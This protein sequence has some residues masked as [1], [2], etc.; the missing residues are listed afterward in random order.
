MS[1]DRPTTASWTDAVWVLLALP[2]VAVALAAWLGIG[3]LR[4]GPAGVVGV[5]AVA[6]VFLP[7]LGITMAWPGARR[8]AMFGLTLAAWSM[9]LLTTFPIYFPGERAAALDRGFTGMAAL[10]GQPLPP[11]GELLDNVL[12]AI[13]GVPPVDS[14]SVV[15]VEDALAVAD[16]VVVAPPPRSP[17]PSTDEVILP[18]EGSGSSLVV[19]VG[20]EH[21]GVDLDVSMIFDTG[22]SFTSVDSQTLR[23]LGVRIPRDAPEVNVRTANGER[24][25]KLV[26][27]DTVWLGGFGVDGVTVAVCDA[28][29]HDNEVGLLGLNVSGRFLVTVDQQ[30]REL[31]L[32][33]RDNP[34]R[35]ADVRYWVHPAAKATAWPDGRVEVDVTLENNSPRTVR[36]AV[37]RI[38]CD[39][40]YDVR[41]PD[42]PPGE[43]GEKQVKLR[44]GAECEGYTVELVSAG[45]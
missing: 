25:M 1:I 4:E 45:W 26:L 37:V 11:L 8:L 28:C 21:D 6:R 20:F 41:L 36:G 9:V 7:A 22:A 23:D 5:L 3:W 39:D 34:D 32:R 10:V 12:P 38:G 2:F 42:V 30:T 29:R 18:Y 24:V 15:A 27:V 43:V 44:T 17:P 40:G 33:P 31:R 35:L 13:Q 14:P 16:P 19:P